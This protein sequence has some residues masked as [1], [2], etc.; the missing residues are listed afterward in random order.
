MK[1]WN[2]EKVRATWHETTIPC[3]TAPDVPR[4]VPPAASSALGELGEGRS[5]LRETQM[6]RRGAAAPCPAQGTA[7]VPPGR[8]QAAHHAATSHPAPVV[9]PL[10]CHHHCQPCRGKEHLLTTCFCSSQT[11]GMWINS[12]SLPL[13]VTQLCPSSPNFLCTSF[14]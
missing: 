11:W 10:S 9:P 4:S 8:Q 7:D 3:S 13:N 5:H 14:Y 6:Q 12:E 1:I 2:T